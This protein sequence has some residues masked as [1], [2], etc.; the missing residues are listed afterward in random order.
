MFDGLKHTYADT[1]SRERRLG[2]R[3]ERSLHMECVNRD[4]SAL[5][6]RREKRK[7]LSQKNVRF[8]IYTYFF[9]IPDHIWKTDLDWLIPPTDRKVILHFL[10]GGMINA[11][12][13]TTQV[14]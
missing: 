5:I 2:V 12:A 7:R 14:S 1:H 3:K 9:F 11:T 13:T 8:K 4:A 6:L 10:T